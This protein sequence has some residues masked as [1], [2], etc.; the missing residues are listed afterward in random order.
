M[1]DENYQNE[2]RLKV[3]KLKYTDSDTIVKL[4]KI[5][6]IIDQEF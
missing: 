6:R 5:M 2:N 1:F 4:Y 3:N